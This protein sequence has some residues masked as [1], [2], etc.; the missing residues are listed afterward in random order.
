MRQKTQILA[1]SWL[2]SICAGPF[3]RPVLA[4]TLPRL[5]PPI[6]TAALR[7]EINQFFRDELA[8]HLGAIKTLD[9]PPER[10]HGA[11]TTGEFT[12]GAFMRGLAAYAELTGERTLAG[13]DL[14][15]WVGQI[16]LVECRAGGKAFSQLYAA[17]ALQHFGAD[18]KS[19]QV[20]QQ[21]TEAER[22]AWRKLLDPA[23]FYDSKT[24]QVINLPENYLG[25]AARIAAIDYQL[26]LLPERRTLDELLDRA[27]RQFTSGSLYADD[28]PP[29][30]RYDR[31][32]N[33]YARFIWYSAEMAGRKDILDALR[34]TMAA[35][36][37]L[38]WDLLSPDGY[39][40]AW[41]RSLG[42]VSY[43]DTM[44]IAAFLGQHPELRP[45]PLTELASAYGLAWRWL[46][47]DYN[48]DTHLLSVFAFGRGNYAYITR[49]REWQQTGAFFS[50]LGAAHKLF[51]DA[52][53]REKIAQF[54]AQPAQPDIARFEFFSRGPGR[55]AGVWI[56]RQGALRFALPITTGP[57]P[58]VADY[59]PAPHGLPGFAAPVEQLYP[60]LTPY[61]ELNDGRVLVAADGADQIEPGT[62]GRSLRVVW[63]RWAVLGRK[64][65]ELT[66]PHLTSEVSWR[67]E[68]T[69]LK[70]DESLTASQPIAIR[71]WWVAIPTTA[72]A[73]IPSTQENLRWNRFESPDG[74][75]E[76]AVPTADWP[77][78][79]SLIAA[80]DG[81]LGRGARGAVPLH[82][83]FE[84]R[85]LRLEPNHPVHWR[86]SLRAF[87]G[88][89]TTKER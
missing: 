82:W 80:G 79:E 70:R 26:G 53:E 67:I 68:G 61:L 51:M 87:S 72:A 45:A 81:A 64:A 42:V 62:D 27:A 47:R 57:K 39:G 74:A 54:P 89:H 19:N 10:V 5:S 85:D 22:A 17:Q 25:V 44:E 59:L 35:Q 11:L 56:V 30:G 3:P 86:L 24:R 23:S 88:E 37:R 78:A 66:D 58:G 60:A 29:T 7:S 2:I 77:L 13:R 28:A 14:A 38:W 83:V 41:G 8:S 12:W 50:K 49:E 18:L 65:G 52:L 4:V 15:R 63:R 21:L 55:A 69:T 73:C 9:P 40:Y 34:P 16:G 75:L 32:S 76:A 31:Y 20:W 6:E 1:L 36:M 33:E 46:R 71:R 48:N 84:S 43:I